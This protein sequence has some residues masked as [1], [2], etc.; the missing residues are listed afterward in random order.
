MSKEE[1][2]KENQRR[3]EK[4]QTQFDNGEV[5]DESEKEEEEEEFKPTGIIQPK[6]KIVHSYSLEMM[7]AWGGYTTSKMDHE[8]MLKS[9]VPTELT[10][11]INLKW[12]DSMKL[13]KLDINDTT[14]VFEYPQIY[15]LDLNLKYK[16]DKDAGSAKFDKKKHTLTIRLP[17]IA[18]TEDSQKVMDEH[19]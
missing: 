6:F 7:D 5:D 15:Y 16:V 14:L 9:K 3:L 19:Y 1:K 12:V 4:A 18:L 13:A 10:V 2:E 11:T 8:T 17:I